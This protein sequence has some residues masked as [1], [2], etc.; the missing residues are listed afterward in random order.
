MHGTAHRGPGRRTARR[1]QRRILKFSPPPAFAASCVG[2]TVWRATHRR[3]EGRDM[4]DRASRQPWMTRNLRR[5]AL[6]V[7]TGLIALTGG[8]ALPQAATAAP[9]HS[10]ATVTQTAAA[11]PL[12]KQLHISSRVVGKTVSGVNVTGHYTPR[13]FFKQ[14][15]H[16]MVRGVL[17]AA[18]HRSNGTVRHITKRGVVLPVKSIGA[19]SAAN[20]RTMSARQANAAL[21]AAPACQILHLVLGPLHLNLLGLHVDLNRVVLNIT[22]QPGPGNLLGNLLCGVAGLLDGG[23]LSG[24]L[25]QLSQLLNSILA[26][27][28]S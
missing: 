3:L 5:P 8:L 22:A 19:P 27:L 24:A 25:G 20:A 9:A 16:L 17:R 12:A 14:N 15:G 2:H 7:G 26:I 6:A 28:N 4:T 21:A 1:A 18:V 23:G 13:H 10:S 11:A